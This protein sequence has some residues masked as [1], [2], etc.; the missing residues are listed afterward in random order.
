MCGIAGI[1]NFRQYPESQV[2]K[3]MLSSI[4]YRGPDSH[5]MS[6][7]RHSA[8]G[9]NRLKIIDLATGDQPISNEDGSVT[10]V[11][12]GEI[13]NY[14]ELREILIRQGHCFKTKSDTEVLV[15]LYEQEGIGFL[16]KLNGMFAF[17]LWDEGKHQLLLARD[18]A[19]IKPLYYFQQNQLL[20]FGSEPKVILAHPTYKKSLNS[21]AVTNYA[22]L[23]YIPGNLSVFAKIDK[24]PAST[25]LLYSKKGK[26]LQQYLPKF[27]H[28]NLSLASLLEDVMIKQQVAD[29]PV[30]VLLSGG[31]DSSL[32]TYFAKKTKQKIKTFSIGFKDP[33][34]D[35]SKYAQIVSDLLHTQHYH[36]WFTAKN[37]LNN[38]SNIIEKMDE[39]FADPSLFPTYLLCGFARKHVTVALSGDGGDELFGGYPTYQGHLW[40]E[41]LSWLPGKEVLSKIFKLLP[42]SYRNLPLRD[43]LILYLR[44]CSLPMRQRHLHWMSELNAGV[45][46]LLLPKY[47]NDSL[48]AVTETQE[49]G[50]LTTL[51]MQRLDY[52]TYL[53][54]DLLVKSDRAAMFHSLELRVPL[55][56]PRLVEFAF[57]QLPKSH[58]DLWQ[59]KKLLRKELRYILPQNIVN[60]SKKGFGIPIALFINSDLSTL[61]DH[62]LE[63]EQLFEFFDRNKVHALVSKHRANKENNGKK[64]W[65]L[66]MLSAW[67]KK[68]SL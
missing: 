28:Q 25:I 23:G 48:G 59:T 33:S 54:D 26:K 55:L 30:G 50:E 42:V 34:F 2:L 18:H 46:E 51:D 14:Q 1:V 44:Y 68:W 57:S 6:I 12:N 66:V 52:E 43:K 27:R 62:Q 19:G 58:L 21:Q 40:A 60:R 20:L 32:I 49:L 5:G 11:F 3:R 29:V 8:L 4:K 35:E 53:R 15:H 39:P 56:D 13:Y 31:I 36:Q 16:S 64:I 61:V 9:I 24:L 7:T 38:F 63:N 41:N 10:V 65:S 67:L 37:I 45:G 17:A 22:Q 47:Q